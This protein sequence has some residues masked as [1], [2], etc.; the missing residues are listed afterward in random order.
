MAKAQPTGTAAAQSKTNGKTETPPLL[1][2]E[3]LET[4]LPVSIAVDSKQYPIANPTAWSLRKRGDAGRAL[5]R[6]FELEEVEEATDDDEA[7]YRRKLI[8]FI[9][10]AVPDLPENVIAKLDTGQLGQVR[11]HFF[12][13]LRITHPRFVLV[14]QGMS[15]LLEMLERTRTGAASSPDSSASTEPATQKSG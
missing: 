14:R 5:R 3:S 7:E 1:T 13:W 2:L 9:S 6:T 4:R 15:M 12:A 8:E 10:M 11:D